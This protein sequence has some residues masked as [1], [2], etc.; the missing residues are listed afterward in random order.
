MRPR[1]SLEVQHVSALVSMVEAGLGIGIVPR[2]SD[3]ASGHGD[4]VSV[5]LKPKLERTI[6][7]IHR[8]GRPLSPV[9]KLLWDLL[10][11]MYGQPAGRGA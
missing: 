3:A 6:G 9:A 5:P 2:L 7:L 1:W 11:K 8:H 4:L 10:V